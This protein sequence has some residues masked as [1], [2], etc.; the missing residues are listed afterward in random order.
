MAAPKANT[1]QRAAAERPATRSGDVRLELVTLELEL[2]D[3]ATSRRRRSRRSRSPRRRPPRGR[4]GS[5]ARS[6]AARARGRTCPAR[7]SRR[8]GHDVAHRTR[9]APRAPAG[10]AAHDVALGDDPGDRLRR[11]RDDHRADAL[12]DEDRDQFAHRWRRRDR[13]HLG[14]L[15]LQHSLIRIECLLVRPGLSVP[16]SALPAPPRWRRYMRTCEDGPCDDRTRSRVESHGFARLADAYLVVA[17]LGWITVV[18][19]VDAHGTLT[20]Q[21]LARRRHLVRAG[22][23][24]RA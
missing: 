14:A 3:R 1:P 5:G 6:S 10:K 19:A 21:R 16:C 15:C 9:P 4:G 24:A 23:A 13:D 12:V 8:R 22:A 18:L 20:I 11:G 2:V 17:A 7:R